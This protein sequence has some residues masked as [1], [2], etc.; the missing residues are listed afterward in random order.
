MADSELLLGKH[1]PVVNDYSPQ[2]LHP[3][4][5]AVGR[6][7]IDA[8]GL[9]A[10][11]GVD[12]WHAYELSWLGAQGRPVVRVGRFKVPATSPNLV[13]SK[14]FKL[15]LNSLNHHRFDSDGAALACI[16]ADVS[17]VA[18]EP[19]TGELFHLQDEC[20]SGQALPGQ[21]LDDLPV[22]YTEQSP[23]RELLQLAPTR[24]ADDFV[25]YTH[26]LRSLCP[27]TGQPDWATLW[28]Q[29][30]GPVLEADSLLRY[31]LA[32]RQ[33]QEF[34]EQCVERIFADLYTTLAPELLTVQAFYT[35]RGGL[36]INPFRS[37]DTD[38]QPR[39]RLNR[40]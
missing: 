18:G 8:G 37:T 23:S 26:L 28:L 40:Q 16:L 35:R 6:G 4:P 11:V 38:A 14:S 9:A 2:L 30:R 25:Y 10:M 1:T 34:H 29:Y 15:Y 17:A 22:A 20:L 32:F 7:E 5:R 19:I 12:V 33:H 24:A 31:L 39:G 21:C 27:V 3:I 36:D 13:E